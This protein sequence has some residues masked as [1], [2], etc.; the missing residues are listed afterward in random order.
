[1]VVIGS[2][3]GIWALS[4]VFLVGDANQVAAPTVT[5]GAIAFERV[6]EGKGNGSHVW[7]VM[8]DGSG[9]RQLTLGDDVIDRWPAWS[10]DGTTIALVRSAPT[11]QGPYGLLVT[12]VTQ[13][14]LRA[15]TPADIGA[16]RPDWSP[17]GRRIAFA[18]VMGETPESGIYVVNADGT[19]LE[20]ITDPRFLAPDNPEW[21]PDGSHI[22]FCANLDTSR[23][24][25][26]V[27]IV[28]ADGSNLR[29]ITNTPDGNESDWVIGWLPNGHLLVSQGPG[30]IAVGPG[31][32]L[33]T[34]RWLEM[35]SSG[36]IVRVVYE[37]PANTSE[38]RQS[39]SISPDGR[40]VLFDTADEGGNT[41]RF[42]D[43][44][45]GEVTAVT[46]GGSTPAWQ[47]VPRTEGPPSPLETP[48]STGP[49]GPTS[50]DTPTELAGVGPVCDLSSARG[51]FGDR[52]DLGTA[53]VYA[54]PDE[55]GGC[56]PDGAGVHRL[57]I[58]VGAGRVELASDPLECGLAGCSTFAAP[59]I[60]GDGRSEIAILTPSS[61]VPWDFVSLYRVAGDQPGAGGAPAIEQIAVE[62]P[63]APRLGVE[64]GP[65][66]I[67]WG[68]SETD[69]YG[70]ECWS[71]TDGADPDVPVLVLVH[72]T[73]DGAGGWDQRYVELALDGSTARVFDVVRAG[74]EGTD[75]TT[76]Y[77]DAFCG[78][79]IQP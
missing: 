18:G 13:P 10:P 56:L 5:N 43:L 54:E 78:S 17:D 53:Y 20:Q 49:M 8:P 77:A 36:E 34:E 14:E 68:S 76:R 26:D 45:T 12:D 22:A 35:T 33:Q 30:E 66:T 74:G 51:D 40:F 63:A 3:V 79:P 58:D 31:L 6:A 75:L 4:R 73:P 41:I 24:S 27:Y 38:G 70:A 32:P 11:G 44:E 71:T 55:A 61:G 42:M 25:W 48:A 23:F 21:S 15:V 9:E 50:T 46:T 37:G 65:L 60:D 1:V 19:E 72:A 39:P 2:I 62:E 28:N 57:G 16:A 29:N 64:P 7:L 69:V 47:P 52:G 67:P 59:D